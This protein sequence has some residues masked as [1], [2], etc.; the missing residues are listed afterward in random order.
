MLTYE[1]WLEETGRDQNE[2]VY[3]EYLGYCEMMGGEDKREGGC[4]V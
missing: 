1:E 3:Y 4:E 2:D